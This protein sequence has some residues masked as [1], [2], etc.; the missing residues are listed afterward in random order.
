[1]RL[2]SVDNL[3]NY[4]NS[5]IHEDTQKHPNHLD[6]TV[7]SIYKIIKPGELDF[8]GGEFREACTEVIDP[9]KKDI[10]DDYGWWNLKVGIYRAVFNEKLMDIDPD[11]TAM[12]TG[13][14]HSEKAGIIVPTQFISTDTQSDTLHTNFHV[15]DVGVNIKEN[16]RFASL[17]LF[18]E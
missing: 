16:A 6:L 18:A 14:I 3:I 11:I 8:G 10:E 1:M 15:P 7:S 13:H 5:V 12:I 17:Y 4:V 9:V 2:L